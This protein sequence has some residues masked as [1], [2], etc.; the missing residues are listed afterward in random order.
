MLVCL[1]AHQRT[2]SLEA[3]ERL[4]VVGADAAPTLRTAHESVQGTV[5]LS[6]CNRFEAYFDLADDHS[7]PVPAMDAAMERM[8][9]LSGLGFRT[10]RDSVDVAQ[11]KRVAEIAQQLVLAAGLLS[12]R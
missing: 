2:T 4:S 10:V 6:T 5:V 12:C 9:S 1:S 7:S 8:A 3:L 11:G